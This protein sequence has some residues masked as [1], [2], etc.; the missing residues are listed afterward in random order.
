MEINEISGTIES[1]IYSNQNTNFHVIEIDYNNT[2]LTVTGP[3]MGISVGEYVTLYGHFHNHDK[4]GYQFI[5]KAFEHKLPTSLIKIE[6]YLCSGIIK[7]IGPTIA[8]RIV[9]KFGVDTLDI[10]EN[11]PENLLQIKG[12]SNNTINTIIKDF[13][14]IYGIKKII[15]FLSKYGITSN[16]CIEIFNQFGSKS[17]EMIKN[18]PYILCYDN[19]SIDFQLVDNISSKISDNFDNDARILSAIIYILNKNLQSGH[20]CLPRDSLISMLCNLI[21]IDNNSASTVIDNML[22]SKKLFQIIKNREYIY[23]PNLFYT[24][25]YITKKLIYL[26]SLPCEDID[27]SDIIYYIQ[28]RFNIV[29]ETHQIE[30]IKSAIKNNILILTGGPGTGKT[31]TLN[32]IIYALEQLNLK[33]ELIAPTGRA[34]KILSNLTNKPAQTVHRI[35]EVEYDSFN[36][37]INFMKNE[38]NLLKCDV[39]IID[40][41]SMIDTL[42]FSSILKA[43]PNKCKIILVG[44]VNQLPS[45][46][47]GNIIK[48]MIESKKI[49]VI[50]LQKIFRQA[51]QSLIVINSHRILNGQ[52]PILDK[53]N[54]DCFFINCIDELNC[55][56]IVIDLYTKRLPTSYSIS[57]IDDIQILIP[58]KKGELGTININNKVQNIINPITSQNTEY[59]GKIYKF[60]E[61]DKVM[62]IK[63]NYNIQW[64]KAGTL[65]LG[66]FNGDIGTILTIDKAAN[67]LKVNFENKIAT[68]TLDML[69]QLE[70][71]YA[72][73]VHKSQGG[74]FNTVILPILGGY[75]K[76]YYR[77]L[78]YTAMSRATNTLIIVGSKNRI[79]YMIDNNKQTLRYT[80]LKYFL[81]QDEII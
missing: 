53:V 28:Q 42:L 19:S 50:T 14:K 75:N 72:I 81:E 47:P 15:M 64:N 38:S 11:N 34:S 40:E 5:A 21:K 49:P 54:R 48:D 57:P 2:L 67:T 66:I 78:L 79:K 45:I 65:G 56:K 23:L 10:L 80:G 51:A 9:E 33:V 31:T 26:A 32:A 29:Y 20:T 63:N 59:A 22:I 4:Y 16:Q 58:S 52:M 43:L 25:K 73:T 44:D 8:K 36:N 41:M 1:I 71:A 62:Q 74:Q 69:N 60:R 77:N 24:E 46:G 6:K 39:I 30:A 18:N 13:K 68:Y 12:I 76:L 3:L 17:I 35:L 55:C 70:L 61:K 7:G 37:K 27:I